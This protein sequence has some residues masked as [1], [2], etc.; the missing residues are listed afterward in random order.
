M[1]LDRLK[2]VNQ[3]AMLEASKALSKFLQGPVTVGMPRVEVKRVQELS[4]ILSP[5]EVVV[6]LSMPL[7]SD[8]V[9]NTLLVLPSE[10]AFA[11]CDILL[12]RERGDTKVI[13]EE[14]QHLLEE[15]GNI[16]VGN[17]LRAFSQG[18]GFKCL[19][20]RAPEFTWDQFGALIRRTIP[21]P[22]FTPPE[23]ALF[24]ELFFD[25]QQATVKGYMILLFEAKDLERVLGET[26]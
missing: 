16:V 6:G 9:G 20:H 3:L 13:A 8:V 1:N 25:F 26:K 24:I 11:F 15:V 12:K 23:E 19:L 2:E 22:V 7:T 14:E 17:Y 10:T 21:S 4:S 18:F 5:G